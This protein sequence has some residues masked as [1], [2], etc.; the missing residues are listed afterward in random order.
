M[1]FL[2]KEKSQPEPDPQQVV[3]K[4]KRKK[5]HAHTKEDEISAFFTVVRPALAEKDN[6]VPT[7]NARVDEDTVAP[8]GGR[9]LQLSTKSSSVVPTVELPGNGSYLG[10]GSRG[11]RH[12]STSYVSWPKSV[13]TQDITPKHPKHLPAVTHDRHGPSKHYSVGST[14]SGVED[15]R[16]KRPAPPT[17]TK[18][19]GEESTERF[20]ISSVAPSQSR[21]SRS[22]SYPQHTSSPRKVN[23]VDRAAKF[24]STQ[25]FAS[26][27]SMPPFVPSHV[28][29]ESSHA[30]PR[31]R[32]RLDEH[33]EMHPPATHQRQ[34][35]QPSDVADEDHPGHAG[36]GTSSDLGR[37]IQH[38][39]HS[40]R[41]QRRATEPH[42]SRVNM[43][44]PHMDSA[45]VRHART[46]LSSR[47]PRRPTVRFSGNEQP[48]PRVP[49]FSGRSIYED[50]AERLHVP[51]QDVL[52]EEDLLDDAYLAEQEV[53]YQQGNMMY[54]E[55]DWEEHLDEPPLYWERI[56]ATTSGDMVQR[57]ASD[58]SISAPGFWRP[59]RLY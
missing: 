3:P 20:Q 26:P 38:C 13:R 59:N 23:L 47:F 16:F 42:M 50:Q 37:V 24:R 8:A 48:A 30:E 25:S 31:L 46:A 21:L 7:N 51:M 9:D 18:Q 49:N 52:D 29:E 10:F 17:V 5:D 44:S 54:T 14:T 33:V 45:T 4:K 56:D 35:Y 19:R 28:R 32:S 1:K 36:Q 55:P 15:T 6:N 22:H 27:S 41:A 40:F 2:Q 12:E 43:D 39:D 34:I 53:I 58:N 57:L 11:P